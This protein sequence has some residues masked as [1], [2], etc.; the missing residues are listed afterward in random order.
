MSNWVIG[1][2]VNDGQT[3]NYIGQMDIDAYCANYATAF[4][5]WYDT[6]KGSNSL[7]CLSRDIHGSGLFG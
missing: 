6:I 2:E 1:N 4:R 3:W 5:T 7:A